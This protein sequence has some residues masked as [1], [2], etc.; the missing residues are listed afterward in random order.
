[1]KVK[2]SKFDIK[3]CAPV[4]SC[5]FL[6][7]YDGTSKQDSFFKRYCNANRRLTIVT[8]G[9]HMWMEFV[10]SVPKI[11]E[12]YGDNLGFEATVTKGIKYLVVSSSFRELTC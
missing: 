7:V 2:F 8:S 5:D 9:E 12:H 6:R 11:R 10:S 4:C 1:M 3:H